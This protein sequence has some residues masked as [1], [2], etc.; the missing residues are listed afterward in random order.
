MRENSKQKGLRGRGDMSKRTK[1]EGKDPNVEV[2]GYNS[3]NLKNCF[4][5]LKKCL[6]SLLSNSYRFDLINL[7]I[8][9]RVY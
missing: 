2:L 6:L 5:M 1:N 3:Y 7:F 9:Q 8:N 4:F